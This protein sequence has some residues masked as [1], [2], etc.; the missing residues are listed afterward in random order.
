MAVIVDTKLQ[1]CCNF[2]ILLL[3]FCKVLGFSVMTIRMTICA[4]SY[5]LAC[6]I[7]TYIHTCLFFR[8]ET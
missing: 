1:L 5:P 3:V 7:F 8:L 2:K 4:A 6:L